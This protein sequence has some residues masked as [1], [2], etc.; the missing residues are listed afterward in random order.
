MAANSNVV[1]TQSKNLDSTIN[2]LDQKLADE[3]EKQKALNHVLLAAIKKGDFE[4]VA[5]TLSKEADVNFQDE[6]G[7][8]SIDA[9]D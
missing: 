3:K 1:T 6:L 2:T 9:C 4:Q 8:N 7:K 5:T